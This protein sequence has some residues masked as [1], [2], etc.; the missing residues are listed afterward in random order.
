MIN[1]SKNDLLLLVLVLLLLLL[2]LLLLLLLLVVRIIY[3]TFIPHL[4]TSARSHIGACVLLMKKALV[5]AFIYVTMHLHCVPHPLITRLRH[6][7]GVQWKG[8]VSSNTAW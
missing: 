6:V 7:P 4:L 5:A 1:S 8:V 3:S 2:V